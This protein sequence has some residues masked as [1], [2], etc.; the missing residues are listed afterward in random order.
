MYKN[1]YICMFSISLIQYVNH[2]PHEEAINKK[3]GWCRD[4]WFALEREAA[5]GYQYIKNTNKKIFDS[6]VYSILAVG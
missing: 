5:C 4:D 3:N 6:Q 2:N 1:K